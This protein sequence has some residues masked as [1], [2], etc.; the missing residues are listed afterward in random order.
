MHFKKVKNPYLTNTS[1]IVDS[2]TQKSQ[3][4]GRFFEFFMKNTNIFPRAVRQSG[5]LLSRYK[6]RPAAI[7][8]RSS[9]F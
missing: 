8:G 4:Q 2:N 3:C 5:V 7:A 1:A 6:K 9:F